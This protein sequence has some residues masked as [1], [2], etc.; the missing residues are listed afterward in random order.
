MSSIGVIGGA[1]GPTRVFVSGP[2][3][4]WAVFGAAAVALVVFLIVRKK[5]CIAQST[6][7]ADAEPW[8]R[9][10]RKWMKILRSDE[11]CRSD[12]CKIT[13]KYFKSLLTARG[14][15]CNI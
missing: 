10:F 7:A 4:P 11:N 5:K 6:S 13:K 9:S 14:I 1:D 8:R 2:V 12:S 3:W 15:Y